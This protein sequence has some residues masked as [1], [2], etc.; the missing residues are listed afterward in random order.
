MF[1]IKL[2]LKFILKLYQL[3]QLLKK[4]LK[5]LINKLENNKLFL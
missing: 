5:N 4:Y 1:F 3:Y 2:D